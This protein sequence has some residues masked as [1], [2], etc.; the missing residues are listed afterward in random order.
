M[1]NV[2]KAWKYSNL[3]SLLIFIADINGTIASEKKG[4]GQSEFFVHIKSIKYNQLSNTYKIKN[5]PNFHFK[6]IEILFECTYLLLGK[7]MSDFVFL[8]LNLYSDTKE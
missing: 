6:S 1:C 5:R 7:N 2:T 4:F 8:N 3:F